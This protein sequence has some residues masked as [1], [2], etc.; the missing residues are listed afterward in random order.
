MFENLILIIETS[1]LESLYKGTIVLEKNGEI[2]LYR[3]RHKRRHTNRG[4]EK[5]SK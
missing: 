3:R 4:V 5:Y 1:L 2:M